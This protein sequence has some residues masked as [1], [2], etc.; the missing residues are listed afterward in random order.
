MLRLAYCFSV[1]AAA[2]L[3]A[4]PAGAQILPTDEFSAVAFRPAPGTHRYLM[5]EGAQIGGTTMPPVDAT[6][7]YS[8][9]A[10]Y[11]RTFCEEPHVRIAC[12]VNAERVAIVEHLAILH[13][14]GALPLGDR[15]ELALSLPLLY[16]DGEGFTFTDEEGDPHTIR[17]GSAA[18]LGDPRLSAR[19]R[20]AGGPGED[21]GFGA[22]LWATAPLGQATMDGRYVGDDSVNVGGHLIA[23]AYAGTTRGAITLG[24]AYRPT[25]GL[26]GV[27][28]TT[29]LTYGA[30]VEWQATEL[31]SLLGEVTGG[32]GFGDSFYQTEARGAGRL[33]VGPIVVTL[34]GGAGL[35]RG[36]GVP[37][38]RVLAGAQWAP[39]PM[40]DLDGDGV[41]DEDDSCP[42][43]AEDAD[44]FADEDGC[45][46]LDNDG[47]RVPDA[48][49][50]CPNES[51]DI[52]QHEDED[53]CP[54][55]DDDGDGVPDGYDSCLDAQEDMDG[56]RDEDGCPDLDADRDGVEDG[57]DQCPDE[58]EDT[59]GL[60]DTDGCPETDADN[61]GVPD[62]DDE[63][64][65]HPGPV[66]PEPGTA[67][68]TPD[69]GAPTG[70]QPRPDAAPPPPRDAGPPPNIDWS[71]P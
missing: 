1:I 37:W 31:F 62:E 60:A 10:V 9:R 49:D 53:G 40:E 30:A 14:G 51:E 21:L 65:D 27:D 26:I 28:V 57:V 69:A 38:V 24:G 71:P 2:V 46:E 15:V 39:L 33:R 20:L 23:E 18:G 11:I 32:I 59:D 42:D 67:P 13:V 29:A 25:R 54:D 52:D 50:R 7:D 45:P 41:A 16:A 47:D 63:C 35:V 48:D 66:C 6:F 58:A 4:A 61:D 5:V 70:P 22:V 56:D 68:P 12:E 64:P 8:W 19:A 36:P 44:D 43:V 3:A 34:G 55:N 17:G